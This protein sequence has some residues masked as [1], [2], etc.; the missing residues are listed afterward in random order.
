[1]SS[2]FSNFIILWDTYYHNRVACWQSGG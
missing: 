1:L 2:L